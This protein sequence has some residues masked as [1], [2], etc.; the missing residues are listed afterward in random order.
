MIDV[1][2]VS[3]SA[4]S[5]RSRS[6]LLILL[7]VFLYSNI[8]PGMEHNCPL[9]LRGRRL[10]R[11]LA[12]CCASEVTC[13]VK[14]ADRQGKSENEVVVESNRKFPIGCTEEDLNKY[15]K[16]RIKL[17]MMYVS[18]M[19]RLNLKDAYIGSYRYFKHLKKGYYKMMESLRKRFYKRTLKYAIPEDMLDNIWEECEAG[20]IGDLNEME[21]FCIESMFDFAGNGRVGIICRGEYDEFTKNLKTICKSFTKFSERKWKA[22]SVRKVKVLRRS[23]K[24]HRKGEDDD[25]YD[26]D[27]DDDYDEEQVN[28]EQAVNP[29]EVKPK[30]EQTEEKKKDEDALKKKQ[31]M[32]LQYLKEIEELFDDEAEQIDEEG[33]QI[34]EDSEETEMEDKSDG[35]GKKSKGKEKKT[36]VQ[37][38]ESSLEEKKSDGKEKEQHEKGKKKDRKERKKNRKEKKKNRKEKKQDGKETKQGGKQI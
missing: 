12:K 26:D 21:D 14:V 10:Q 7:L 6:S 16:K 22:L 34:K 1:V 32:M 33:E 13:P 8:V 25:E 17:N 37:E 20:L 27:D 24:K 30:E 38:E 11:R 29:V 35:K 36:N 28:V 15:L 19:L 31:E 3:T 9:L 2:S 5:R 4:F 23:M 18:G